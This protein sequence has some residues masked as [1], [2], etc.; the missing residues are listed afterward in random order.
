M[1]GPGST[2]AEKLGASAGAWAAFYL[3][4]HY[5]ILNGATADPTMSAAAYVS[6]LVAERMRW[7]SATALR[8][9]AGIMIVWFMGS[10][11]GRLRTAEGEPARLAT[12]TFG[13]GTLWGGVWLV[14]AMFNSAAILLATQYQNPE[15]A[16][17]AG[18]FAKE[19]PLILTPAL[20]F[21]LILSTG[22]ATLRYGGYSRA[23]AY[24]TAG[25]SLLMIIL[26]LVEWYG[27]GNL[28]AII[29]TVALGWT[30]VTSLL[31]IQPY[32][33]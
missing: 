22:F 1:T 28:G 24:V 23:Y 11:A 26:A 9:M 30:A 14:S 16:R 27:P 7:E 33:R 5:F 15:G 29:M 17:L 2:L 4:I 10:L 25:L 8:V 18:M 6:T 19:T 31:T 21:T 20:A 32:S 3:A 12:I 13:I